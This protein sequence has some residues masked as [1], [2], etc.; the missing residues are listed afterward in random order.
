MR[1]EQI[2]PGNESGRIQPGTKMWDLVANTDQRR[3]SVERVSLG[4][5][6]D[7]TLQP[8]TPAFESLARMDLQRY[9]TERRLFGSQE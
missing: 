1:I 7:G 8:G 4:L 6:P 3:L 2:Q 9:Q 5:A